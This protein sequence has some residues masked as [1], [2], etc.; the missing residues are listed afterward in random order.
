MSVSRSFRQQARALFKS[1]T[2]RVRAGMC[3]MPTWSKLPFEMERHKLSFG[4][5]HLELV[6]A[7]PTN[8]LT[9]LFITYNCD[10]ADRVVEVDT[11][12]AIL[13]TLQPLDAG[14]S[15]RV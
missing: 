4:R 13:R 14:P 12:D 11:I 3:P 6:Q 15:D 9:V 7:I 10:L 5:S 2:E 1:A 8:L